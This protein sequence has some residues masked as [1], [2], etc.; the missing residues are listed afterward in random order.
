MYMGFGC[1]VCQLLA[2]QFHFS[3][4][5]LVTVHSSGLDFGDIQTDLRASCS[6]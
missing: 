2:S 4:S 1:C 6:Y 3:H 5:Y